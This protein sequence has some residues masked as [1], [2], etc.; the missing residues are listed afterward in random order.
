M[1]RKSVADVVVESAYPAALALPL[2]STTLGLE[3]GK[4]QVKALVALYSGN[5]PPWIVTAVRA[6]SMTLSRRFR[7]KRISYRPP[8]W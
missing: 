3:R 5:R 8:V 2:L 1:V 4:G 6:D 7:V